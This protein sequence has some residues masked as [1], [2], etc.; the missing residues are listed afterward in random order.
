MEA[1]GVVSTIE[2]ELLTTGVNVERLRNHPIT[3]AGFEK[4]ILKLKTSKL[5][6]IMENIT[7]YNAVSRTLNILRS[8]Y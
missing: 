3:L 6:A 4:E 7:A 1:M 5:M 2:K 8:L